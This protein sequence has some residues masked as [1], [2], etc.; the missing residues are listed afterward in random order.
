MTDVATLTVLDTEWANTVAGYVVSDY[1]AKVL[2]EDFKDW[3][4]EVSEFN[5]GEN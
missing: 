1:D 3:L 2:L 5:D 4:D